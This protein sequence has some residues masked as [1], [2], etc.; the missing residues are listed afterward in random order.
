VTLFI[1]SSPS[2]ATGRIINLT[3]DFR[4]VSYDSQDS[5]VLFTTFFHP[6]IRACQLYQFQ[7]AETLHYF[8]RRVLF[9][10]HVKTT[11]H[12]LLLAV[13]SLAASDAFAQKVKVGYDKQTDFSKYKT[14][15]WA[16]PALPAARPVLFEAVIARVDV[17][18]R[19]KNL[20]HVPSGGDLTIMPSGGVNFGIAGEA[21]TPYSPTYGGPP[22]MLN[23]TMWTGPGGTS[24][25]GTYVPEGTLVLTF[26][27]RDSNK[28]VW[29][30]SVKQKL[31][32]QKKTKS[33]E[34]ADKAVIKLLKEFPAKK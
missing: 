33:L 19:S 14:Y 29:S 32:I 2:F 20:S 34:L 28:V 18:L 1:N 23:A 8:A 5:L 15:S 9:G 10:G 30:G 24:S 26:V 25:A 21:S 31:D 13:V 22:P 4:T 3:A 17:E 27:E 11:L 12:I 6:A 16:Q 7:P